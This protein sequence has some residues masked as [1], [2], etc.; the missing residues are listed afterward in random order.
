[1]LNVAPRVTALRARRGGRVL[2]QIDGHDW[3]ELPADVVVRARLTP[4]TE[5]DR[6]RLREVA[7]ERRRTRSLAA[8]GRVLRVR[9][10]PAATLDKRLERRGIA[11]ADR[12]GALSTLQAAG[13]VDD[14]RFAHNR[15]LALAGRCLGDAAIR[16]DL[17]EYG[18]A[19]D[20]VD[21]ALAGVEPE[22]ARAARIV[23]T[24]GRSITTARFL[25]RKGFGEDAVES[26]AGE[27]LG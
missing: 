8:A 9:D 18:I 26:A 25:A 5:L 1:V 22:A 14:A 19:P 13:V 16:F 7:R 11:A 2:V 6:P 20:L 4:G 24:R 23:A 3:R 27:V 21:D 15:A 10:L 12:A 17:E